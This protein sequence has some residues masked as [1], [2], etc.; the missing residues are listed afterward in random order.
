M[1]TVGATQ[2]GTVS[3]AMVG[4]VHKAQFYFKSLKLARYNLI[5]TKNP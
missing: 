3:R 2:S 5:D 4:E 1:F